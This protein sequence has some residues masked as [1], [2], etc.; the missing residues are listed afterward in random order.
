MFG[1]RHG[2]LRGGA[3]NLLALLAS[4]AMFLAWGDDLLLIYND[5]YA[6]LLSAKHP[7]ALGEPFARLWADV[8]SQVG[9]M[10]DGVYLLHLLLQPAGRAGG[11]G[12]VVRLHGDDPAGGRGAAAGCAARPV[13]GV[14]LR[15]RGARTATPSRRSR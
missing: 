1:D 8:S 6:A 11:I 7:G 3:M 4:R 13:G 9:L 12:A 15:C 14:A 10:V 2:L 5:A